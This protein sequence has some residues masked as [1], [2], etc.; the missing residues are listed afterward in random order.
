MFTLNDLTFL[1]TGASSGIGACVCTIISELGGRV[2]GFGRDH[3]RLEASIKS[4][5]GYG[6][7]GFSVELTN[8]EKVTE[9]VKVLGDNGVRLNGLVHCAGVHSL[10]TMATQKQEHIMHVLATNVAA[11]LALTRVVLNEKI[12][13][14]GASIVFLSSAAAFRGEAALSAYTAS[15]GALVSVV[16]AL[17]AELLPR[18]IRVNAVAPGLI[19]TPMSRIFLSKLSAERLIAVRHNHPFGFG[20]VEDVARP[21]TFLLSPAA[22]FINGQT[23]AIDGGLS[24]F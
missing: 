17:A 15:K 3:A 7:I 23:L 16:R 21:I 19:D 12:V 20:V 4:L 10:R 18:N 14:E 13:S 6:H 11:P 22:R 9:A 5:N 2:V 1:V 24:A 8:Q